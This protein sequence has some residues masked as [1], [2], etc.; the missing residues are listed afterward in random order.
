V[1][2]A[3]GL[4]YAAF[5]ATFPSHSVGALV[6]VLV[7]ATAVLVAVATLRHPNT[8]P[9][10]LGRDHLPWLVLLLVFG[11]WELSTLLAGE[12]TFSLL[13]DPVLEIYPLRV[14][15]WVLWL[16]G[17]RLLVRP[18]RTAGNAITE[19]LNMLVATRA[20]RILTVLVWGWLGWHFLA[21]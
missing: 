15:G 4:A 6:V 8:K 12:L 20:S 19:L 18:G 14:A 17:G 1:P 2:L 16:W 10:R 5:G 9:A 3:A 21:R 13:M 7:P 11:V